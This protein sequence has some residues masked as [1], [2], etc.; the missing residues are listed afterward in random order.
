MQE[1]K[2]SNPVS[3]FK[4]LTGVEGEIQRD[5][6]SLSGTLSLL[7]CTVLGDFRKYEHSE[8]KKIVV[9]PSFLPVYPV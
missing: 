2:E 3:V 7:A 1:K 8:Q 5:E 4:L 9:K 6:I